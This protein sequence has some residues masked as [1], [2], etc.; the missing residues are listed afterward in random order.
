VRNETAA[1]VKTRFDARLFY[2]G[3]LRMDTNGR[4]ILRFTAPPLD[5]ASYAVAA[6]CPVC[7]TYSR[8]RKF[9]TI[10]VDASI[11]P[12]YRPLML[13][14][15]RLPSATETCPVTHPN[16]SNPPLEV[17]FRGPNYHGNGALWVS[18]SS[19][20]TLVERPDRIDP[21]GT[22]FE[23]LIW[24][25]DGVTGRL[26]VTAERLDR[27]TPMQRSVGISGW[28]TGFHGSA[29][30]ASRFHFPPDSCWR[31]TGR[32]KDVSLVYVMRVVVG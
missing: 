23:K 9:S 30:W 15:V 25:A 7:A 10:A 13:L 31:I 26:R 4:G 3:T 11:V 6:W 28:S 19:N 1:R 27:V 14:K 16:G 22:F 8:G 24:W 32:V 5:S 29:S 2:I 17:Q 12:R 20:G 21:D 18:L